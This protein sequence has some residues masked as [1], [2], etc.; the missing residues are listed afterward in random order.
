[1][2]GGIEYVV[3]G[4]IGPMI[5]EMDKFAPPGSVCVVEEADLIEEGDLTARSARY[6]CVACVVAGPAQRQDGSPP[7]PLDALSTARA[8]IPGGEYVVVSTAAYAEAAGLPGPGMR[9]ALTVRNKAR[10]REA[11]LAAGITQP[12]FGYATGPDDV[13][14]FRSAHGGHC[15]LKP[16]DRWASIGVQVLGPDDDV[17]AAWARRAGEDESGLRS[18]SWTTG[19]YLV[20]EFVRG[21]EVSVELLVADGE[22]LFANVT[23][24]SLFPGRHPVE[25]GHVVPA[26]IDVAVRD[27]LLAANDALIAAVGFG[28]GAIHSEWILAG[29]VPYLVECAGR[30]PGDAIVPLIDLSY[31]CNLLKLVTDLLAGERPE[32]PGAPRGGAAVR[33]LTERPGIV[34]AIHGMERARE[35][36]GVLAAIPTVQVGGPVAP[37]ACS[38]D[39]VGHVVTTGPDGAEADR[40]AARAVSFISYEIEEE[41][42]TA[43][44]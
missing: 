8:V 40:R 15:V 18:G 2:T 43:A 34:R 14:A 28:T 23:A 11:A 31:D 13:R 37:L 7:P 22:R 41:V 19:E 12:A 29:G 44:T 21:S 16:A 20:E 24:K 32:M 1:M 26:P 6:E 42:A 36:E 4:Y 17:D 39:R 38:W 10:L 35:V 27:R 30:L 25:A 9:A 5:A 33:F 3:V